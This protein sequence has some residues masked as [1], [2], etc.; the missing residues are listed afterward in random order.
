MRAAAGTRLLVF[1]TLAT[2]A[3]VAMPACKRGAQAPQAPPKPSLGTVTVDNRSPPRPELAPSRR[4]ED[5]DIDEDAVAAA[6]RKSLLASGLFAA[7]PGDGGAAPTAR[8]RLLFGAECVEL[9]AKGEARAQVRLRVDTR[10]SE[11]PG[12]V[13]FDLEGQG[14]E[15]YVVA[16]TAPKGKLTEGKLAPAAVQPEPKSPSLTA[17][18]TRIT[19]DLIEGVAARR[20]LQEGSP[21]ALHA[22]LVADGGELREEAIRIVGERQLRDE[23]PTLLKLLSADEEPIRDAALGAL[24]A[25]RE[26][27]AVR[28]LT[29]SRSLRDR[30]EMRKIIEAISILG[31]QEA[32]EYLSFVAATHD[33]DEIKTEAASARTRLQRREAEAGAGK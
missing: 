7:G 20:R 26:R 13:A 29:R 31:G 6:L 30:R 16:P 24:I 32:D 4:P 27:S 33:D 19:G 3:A 10:P 1:S 25:M 8:A 11:A 15:P 5:L 2:F 23:V 12:A 22:A 28:E 17:L 21:G 9:G 14:S 18:V